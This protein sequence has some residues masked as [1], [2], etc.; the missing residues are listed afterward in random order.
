MLLSVSFIYPKQLWA[1]LATPNIK[2]LDMSNNEIVLN[3][4]NIPFL[5]HTPKLTQLYLRRAFTTTS[6]K[7]KQFDILMRIFEKA[8]LKQ[9]KVDF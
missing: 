8:Q 2:V 7:T 5:T 1:I 6:N 3:D 9:L 4:E